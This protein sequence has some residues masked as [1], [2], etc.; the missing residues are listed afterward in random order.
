MTFHRI[1]SLVAMAFL[2]T[3][4]Q[5]PIYLFG[6]QPLNDLIILCSVLIKT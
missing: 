6:K 3:G 5:I 2:W 1:M 4:S